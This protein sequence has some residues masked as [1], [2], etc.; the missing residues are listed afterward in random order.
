MPAKGQT[1][2]KF[3]SREARRYQGANPNVGWAEVVLADP[4]R[5]WGLMQVWALKALH[6]AGKSHPEQDCPLCQESRLENVA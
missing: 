1:A 4:I 3:G 5:Y 2:F 6:R